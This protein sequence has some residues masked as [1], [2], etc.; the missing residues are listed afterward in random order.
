MKAA[1]IAA[2]A[3]LLGG[4]QASASGSV[5]LNTGDD[6]AEVQ[7][8]DKPLEAPPI[9]VKPPTEEFRVQE[10]ALLGARH[11][12][13]YAGDATARC[14]CLAVSLHDRAQHPHFAWDLTPPRLQPTTQSVIALSSSKVA[15]DAPS[16]DTLGASYQGYEVRGDDV[17]VFVEP[18]AEGRPMTQGAII[19]KPLGRGNVFI[20]ASGGVYGMP[21][22]GGGSLCKVDEDAAQAP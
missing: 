7:D 20:Q 10:Y 18:L 3:A 9:E 2:L 15:C 21:L 19:P 17:I 6:E 4:C 11:D 5:Q 16:S 12:L 13:R 8:F 1:H 22:S 14:Q